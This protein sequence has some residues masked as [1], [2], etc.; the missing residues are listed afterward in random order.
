MSHQGPNTEPKKPAARTDTNVRYSQVSGGGGER[1][2]HHGH[3]AKSNKEHQ[4]NR[5]QKSLPGD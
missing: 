1:D 3:D 5:V 4:Q 2:R